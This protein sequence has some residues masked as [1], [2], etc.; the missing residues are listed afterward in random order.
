MEGHLRGNLYEIDSVIAPPTARYD[1][2]FSARTPPNLDLWH[3]HMGHISLKSLRYLERHQ[4]VTGFDLRGNGELA[5]CNGCAKGKHHQAPFPPTTTNCTNSILERLHM[6]LQGPFDKSILGYRYTLGVIDDYSR[7]GW[8]EYLK[9]KDEA[10]AL[11][12]TLIQRLETLT[13]QRVKY[14]RSDRGGEFIDSRL[15]SYL[16]EKG[17]THEMTAPH[18]PQQNGVAERFNQTTHESA[19]AMLEDAVLSRGF[20]PEAHDYANYVRNRSP[21]K[22]LTHSTP[23]EAFYGKKPSVA[24][25]RI[26]GSRCHV[27]IPPDQRRKLD[28]HSLDGTFCGFECQSKAYKVWVPTK[29]KFVAS[30][31][32]IIYEK[33][34]TSD[35][36]DPSPPTALSQGVPSSSVPAR[37]EGVLLD[38]VNPTDDINTILSKPLVPASLVPPTLPPPPTPPTPAPAPSPQPPVPPL[39]PTLA[40]RQL[41]RS[42]RVTRPSWKKEAA[43]KQKEKEEKEKTDR[44]MQHEIGKMQPPPPAQ[45]PEQVESMYIGDV[46]QLAYIAAHGDDIPCSLKEAIS[47]RHADM[48]TSGGKQCRRRWTCYRN[49]EPGS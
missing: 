3:A 23:N 4:L 8:K 10:P 12:K 35:D 5:P 30:R 39:E 21:T 45:K 25:L 9:H 26:F 16:R 28:A 31:D 32:V 17:I 42:E 33:V 14:I 20:W 27:H 38:T 29:H 48:Q 22:A 44:K 37:T 11:L 7:K 40:P 6:D 34:P 13:G 18:T 15:Q 49:E 36:D 46:A 19:L 43:D 2:A 24:T 41:R 47:G 1:A